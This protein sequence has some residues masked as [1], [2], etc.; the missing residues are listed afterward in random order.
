MNIPEITMDALIEKYD[1]ILFDAYGVLVH[2]SGA[3]PGARSL[4]K[5]LN[6]T[7]KQYYILTNDASKL[8][9]TASEC[10]RGFG[11]E[12]GKERIVSSGGLIK[13]Y[14]AAHDLIGQDCL[15]LGPPDS[16]AFVKRAG[17]NIVSSRDDFT[18]LII[19]DDAGFPFMET[20]DTVFTNLCRLVD[21]DKAVHLVL[22]NPDL[23]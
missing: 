20:V 5:R 18:V 4:I 10:Y 7:G 14:F 3:L 12:I 11:L 19:A 9:N 23:I 16:V 17:G 2:S 13:A 21:E 6:Q 1:T 15:V 8:P 22:P